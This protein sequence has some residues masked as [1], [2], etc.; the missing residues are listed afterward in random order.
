MA[1]SSSS[2]THEASP[3]V[4]DGNGISYTE[5]KSTSSSSS[6]S[7]NDEAEA[8]F[9]CNVCLE[10]TNKD[11]VVTQCGHL[12]C[13]PCLYRWLNTNHSTCPVCKASVTKENVI[14]LFIRGSEEDPRKKSPA[15]NNFGVPSRPIGHRPEPQLNFMQ[16]NGNLNNNSQ[17]GVV[18]F[19]AGFGFFPSLFGLQFQSFPH[20]A[21]PPPGTDPNRQ[22]TDEE[23]QQKN[24]SKALIVLGGLVLLA[25]IFF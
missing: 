19:T 24:L 1:E 11:P 7:N 21:T 13:W 2:I 16:A 10:I 22:L 4:N 6:T 18:T 3:L 5:I 20:V 12:Y 8:A 23:I 17:Y 15:T 9:I 25:L 14:P